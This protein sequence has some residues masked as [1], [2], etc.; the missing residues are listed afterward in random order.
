MMSLDG[1]Q[2]MILLI[3]VQFIEWIYSNAYNDVFDSS[4]PC[5][6]LKEYSCQVIFVNHSRSAFA[7]AV[8]YINGCKRTSI[9]R[10]R[11]LCIGE[12][13]ELSCGAFS[14]MNR[15]IWFMMC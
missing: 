3:S 14:F 13:C 6:V 1:S 12:G 11:E 8:C 5:L 2:L 10:N 9:V 15:S 4:H 7:W